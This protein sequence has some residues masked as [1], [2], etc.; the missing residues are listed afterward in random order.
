MDQELEKIEVIDIPEK[1]YV[2][3]NDVV[4]FDQKLKDK[5]IKDGR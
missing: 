2:D 4:H 3:E 5:E 1:G